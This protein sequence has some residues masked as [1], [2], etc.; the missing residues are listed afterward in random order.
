M[1]GPLHYRALER[2]KSQA[3]KRSKGDWEAK[4]TLSRDSLH[5]IQTLQKIQ[6]DQAT[7][8]VVA[9]YWPNQVYYPVLIEMLIDNPVILTARNNLL[10]L[11]STPYK[12]HRLY[13]HLKMLVCRVSGCNMKIT[14]FQKTLSLSHHGDLTPG[15]DTQPTS[16]NGRNLQLRGIH[17][18]HRRL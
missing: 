17:I 10:Q 8:V 3:L 16:A 9:P 4:V 15:K 7:G 18:P 6:E 14:A 5:E 13:K 12:T 11:P 1:H 2:K